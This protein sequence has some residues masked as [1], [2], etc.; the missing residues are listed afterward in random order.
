VAEEFI[1]PLRIYINNEE[2]DNSKLADHWARFHAQPGAL[3]DPE[4]VLPNRPN[5]SEHFDEYFFMMASSLAPWTRG[6]LVTVLSKPRAEMSTAEHEL[7][8]RL[9]SAQDE[10]RAAVTGYHA[11]WRP[12]LTLSQPPKIDGCGSDTDKDREEFARK[13]FLSI[14]SRPGLAKFLGFIIDIEIKADEFDRKLRDLGI[15][16]RPN[17]Y[18]YIMADFGAPDPGQSGQGAIDDPGARVWTAALLERDQAAVGARPPRNG[19]FGPCSKGKFI[20]ALRAG[21]TSVASAAVGP[22]PYDRGVLDLAAPGRDKQPRF[23]IIDFDIDAALHAWENSGLDR[24]TALAKGAMSENVAVAMP[25]LRTRGLSLIDRDQKSD[26]AQ[27]AIGAN[28]MA[29]SALAQVF[30]AEELV[31]GYRIDVGVC[32]S[33]STDLPASGRWRSLHRR[34]VSY[35]PHDIPSTY[36]SWLDADREREDGFAKPIT[37][38]ADVE[39]NGGPPANQY[40]AQDTLAVWTGNSLAVQATREPDARDGAEDSFATRIHSYCELGTNIA[41]SLPTSHTQALPPLRFGRGYWMGARLVYANGASIK[42]DEA[43]A[44]HYL[45][46]PTTAVG[47]AK[48]PANPTEPPKGFVFKR[49]ERSAAPLILLPPDDSSPRRRPTRC[50]AKPYRRRCC[51]E[52]QR[53]DVTWCREA[54]PSKSPRRMGNST[55]NPSREAHSFSTREITITECFRP[56]ANLCPHRARKRTIQAAC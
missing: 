20:G 54:C 38:V 33:R 31:V 32:T 47:A 55:K 9:T 56:H 1:K 23:A 6:E 25:D 3:A 43:V 29:S 21:L 49:G 36:S 17:N 40:I 37:R 46:S 41:F 45:D 51:V 2:Q 35:D 26:L 24:S 4:P 22:L 34:I 48:D 28:V 53:R 39:H 8:D 12:N 50:K 11:A 5:I 15:G 30:Y 27:Q 42:L 7:L 19:S 10:W 18:F 44:Q 52:M 14:L 16:D 13:K